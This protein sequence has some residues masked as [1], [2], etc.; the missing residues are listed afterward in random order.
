[1]P[2]FRHPRTSAPETFRPRPRFRAIPGA[3]L[4]KLG[5]AAALAG[6]LGLARL[7]VPGAAIAA[8]VADSAATTAAAPTAAGANDPA[9]VEMRL[10]DDARYLAADEREGRGVGTQG[11]EAAADFIAKEFAKAGLKTDLW[12]GG[13]FQKFN[14]TTGQSL[15][16]PNSLAFV[17]P[18]PN[19]A[20]DELRF[21]LSLETDFTP[22]AIG[23]SGTFDLPLVFVGY[24]ITANKEEYDDYAGVDVKGKAVLVLR[25]EPQQGNPHSVFE[26][27]EPSR[28][29]AF[30]R[31][32]S[33]AYEHGA[34]AVIFCSDEHDLRKS[35]A[36][37]EK[38]WRAAVDELAQ[39]QAKL[40]GLE[41]PTDETL[42]PLRDQIDHTADDIQRAAAAWRNAPREVLKFDGAGNQ[43]SGRD[44]PV[45]YCARH[46]A[47]QVVK[48][49]TGEE[50]GAIEAGIDKDLKPHSLELAGWRATGIT[51]VMQRKV[52]AKNV[53]AVLEGAGPLSDETLIIGAH[54]DHLG[55]GG[56]DSR[57]PG[58]KEIHNGAD[59]NAS[60][61]AS[62]IEIARRLAARPEK[63]P[64]RVLF[65]AFTGEEMGLLGSAHYV[66]EPLYPLDKT[67]AMLN[68]DMVGRLT[69]RKLIVYGTG[70][71]SQFEPLVEQFAKQQDFKLTKHASG[72]GPSDQ[73][74]FYAAHIPVLHF[75]TGSHADYHL[76]SDDFEKLNISGMREIEELVTRMAVA[77][78]ESP[79]RPD[80]LE[81]RPVVR[82][83]GDR[84]YFGSIPDFAQD[85]PG[86]A[87][88]GVAKDSPAQRAGIRAGDVIV[89]LGESRIG[90]LEDFDSALRK[91]KAGERVPVVVRRGESE[92][93]LEVTLDPP[94]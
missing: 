62:L 20:T 63:L 93:T 86:Y 50:L 66:R 25:H 22:L 82:G 44:M 61:A 88:T 29:A 92:Q 35:A 38:R 46:F 3:A 39:Q 16:S 58:S 87:L 78:C 72:F 14:I 45:L 11:L 73:S 90:N 57:S 23:G 84:P 24:G 48:A 8:D 60:G 2:I 41:H 56:S 53:G 31:K 75:F 74:S 30:A 26:G 5:F 79:K 6:S 15:G 42:L 49:A 70:T 81:I 54:Y 91:F 17:G 65:L 52:E 83:G 19:S 71:S 94:R 47:E 1:M 27:T 12:N 80:Y 76:P 36:N 7:T 67:V 13:P 69:D 9:E 40:K 34:A 43:S 18:K 55:F 85:K 28:H 21:E 51:N 77:V 32:A 4:S 37:W 89:R 33:N 59:D 68:M 10:A 64:R